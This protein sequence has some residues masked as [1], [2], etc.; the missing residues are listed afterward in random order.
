M[1]KFY[2][3]CGV[4][5]ITLALILGYSCKKDINSVPDNFSTE[6]P[7]NPE[8]AGIGHNKCLDIFFQKLQQLKA[9][10]RSNEV[11]SIE[12]DE[13][14]V[15]D[16][17]AESIF[18]CLENIEM[19][20]TEKED[21][22]NE[23]QTIIE[24]CDENLDEIEL[25]IL[26]EQALFMASRLQTIIDTDNIDATNAINAITAIE[27]EARQNLSESEANS[28]LLSTAIMRYSI[29]YWN[30]NYTYWFP[31]QTRSG[32]NWRDIAKADCDWALIAIGFGGTKTGGR[33]LKWASRLL[34]IASMQA[35]ILII[36]SVAAAGSIMEATRNEIM[37]SDELE[38][39]LCC[40][41]AEKALRMY[42]SDEEEPVIGI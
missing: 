40:D 35:K 20:N 3:S 5:L 18:E 36:T 15:E 29:E 16:M 22:N 19:E 17:I 39:A 24:Y 41:I 28:L 13:V 8:I 11:G 9:Q 42:I 26:S 37:I 38:P 30:E 27:N 32:S 10:T 12:T 21:L 4:I 23:L 2:Y 25:P 34:G 1:K 6:N 33:A 14:V 31:S 7:I